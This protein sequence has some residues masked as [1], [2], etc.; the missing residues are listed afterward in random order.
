MD[1]DLEVQEKPGSMPKTALALT[2]LA[3]GL[4]A[5]FA[6]GMSRGGGE[7]SAAHRILYY[8]DP[9]HPHYRSDRAGMAPDCGMDLV[10][11]YADEAGKAIVSMS[12]AE[13][14][15][16]KIDSSMQQLYGIK[17]ARV[18]QDRGKSVIQVFARVVPDETKIYRVNFGTDGYV[19]E[20]HDDAV[21]MFVKK[22]QHLATVYSPDFLSVSGGFL[23]ARERDPS[24]MNARTAGGGEN[25]SQ[26]AASVQARADRLRNLGMSDIQIQEITRT[27]KLP[28]DVY[29]VSPTDGFILSRTISPGMRFQRQSDLY[30]IAD[31]SHVWIEAE[32]YG[33][34]AEAFHAGAG[35]AVTM[36]ETGERIHA[37]VVSVLPEVDPNTRAVKVRLEA[38]NP[39]GRLRPNMFVSVEVPVSVPAGLSVPAD[40]IM[41][42]GATKRV[43]VQVA[44]GVFEPRPV[45]TG[46]QIGD[47]VQVV[48]GLAPDDV[49]VAS[50]TFLVDSESRLHP[51]AI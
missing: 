36:R 48:K 32:V 47:R 10:P 9:M 23:A 19:K 22:N 3:I 26:E 27:R 13:A 46:W 7:R 42:S 39:R 49:V 20:T 35:A 29:V 14:G 12:N 28:E 31:L 34:T 21:G 11:V 37:R 43:Y 24:S 18:E 51:G 30:S 4:V 44:D 1:D 15:K 17:L 41:N 40:S 2:L 33:R 50:G 45:E 8:Q 5:G 6:I 25:V 16:A 38:E